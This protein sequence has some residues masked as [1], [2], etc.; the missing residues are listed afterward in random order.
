MSSTSERVARPRRIGAGEGGVRERSLFRKYAA[1]FVIVVGSGIAASGAVHSY[2][3]YR[4][5]REALVRLQREKAMA[6][7]D[8][9]RQF[10][11][12]LEDDVE[13]VTMPG[14]PTDRQGLMRRRNEDR[15][16][17]HRVP[18]IAE[19]SYLDPSGRERLRVSRLGLDA[20]DSGVDRSTAPS[21]QEATSKEFYFGPVYFKEG[22]E[23]YTTVAI[24]LGPHGG[25]VSAQASLKYVS[26]L[27]GSI[28]VGKAGYAYAVDSR[29]DLIV[30]R[31]VSAVLRRT[32]LSSLPQVQAALAAASR[33]VPMR[34]TVGRDP[35]GRRVLTAEQVI[36][37][38]LGWHVF[39]EQPLSQAYASLDASILRNAL[40]LG[41]SL[42][43]AALTGLFLARRMVGPIRAL[44]AGAARIG[45]G[46]LD[47]QIHVR[48]GDELEALA[49]AFNQMTTRLRRSYEEV[50]ASRA[51]LVMA[52]DAERRRIEHDIHDGIQPGIVALTA[53]AGLARQ[54]LR[55][56]PQLADATL[57]ELQHDIRKLLEDLREWAHGIHPSVLSDHGLIEAIEARIERIPS[58]VVIHAEARLRGTRYADEIEVAA[59]YLVS[60]G[61][62]NALKHARATTAQVTVRRR[63]GRLIVEVSDDGVG[64]DPSLVSGSGI[65][66]LADR[67][68]AVG[69][70]LRID[71]QSGAG[72]RL[73]AEFPA[74]DGRMAHRN[75]DAHRR[76]PSPRVAEIGEEG[77]VTVESAAT[78]PPLPHTGQGNDPIA[79]S[80]HHIPH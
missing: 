27:V 38:P 10:V 3:S 7:A 12:W 70:K 73:F 44:E 6:A 80:E 11:Q 48:T 19:V 8:S 4:D 56:S 13:S 43:L 79:P 66:N 36:G 17:L 55:R 15:E 31:D 14:L 72:T 58:K 25:V 21:F 49:D 50:E 26:D 59:F 9:I 1:V 47:H 35:Q 41:A 64:F 29:G 2:L 37:P 33:K 18:A 63:D 42:V 65:R 24:S 39:V 76:P 71:S 60:E 23:P 22:S 78:D 40:L 20:I 57:V 74:R 51:R 16:L 69:G 46:E 45:S 61:L 30:H 77:L 28:S 68:E 67:V 62:A 54:Q 5:N 32:N 34:A 75:A 53:K 52:A